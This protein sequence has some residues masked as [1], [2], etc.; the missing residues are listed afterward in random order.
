MMD[1]AD[2]LDMMEDD[3]DIEGFPL[4][5]KEATDGTER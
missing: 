4:E 5:E 3:C 2:R 1:Y